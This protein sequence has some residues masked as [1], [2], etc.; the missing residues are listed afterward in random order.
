MVICNNN[1]WTSDIDEILKELPELSTL[2]GKTIMITGC[3]GLICSAVVDVLI[4]WNVTH[5]GKIQ[6][7]AAGR[8][9]KKIIER[10]APYKNER[11][12]SHV[13]YDA[14]SL[15]NNL[16]LSCDY[17]IHGASNAAP[18][19]IMR[20]PVETM[21]SNFVGVK[22]LLDYAKAIQVKRILYI[23]SSEVYGKKEVDKPSKPTEYGWIDILSSRSSYSIGKCA[24]ETLCASYYDEYG[25]DSVIVR[26]GHI[27]G[28]TALKTDSRV[29]SLWAHSVACGED[30][31]MKST[32][33]Q[34]R[35]Y[36][37][38]LDC[39]SAIIT[40]LLKG[41]SI[42]AYN[43]S[44]PDKVNIHS[45]DN[46]TTYKISA[47][48]L[49]IMETVRTL[50]KGLENETEIIAAVDQ[51]QDNV[52]KHSFAEKYNAFIQSIA[53]HMT[54]FAPFIPA[55]SALLTK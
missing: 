5:Q 37:Y 3:T 47:N 18:S 6:I 25:V 8:S 23:S 4:R 10:F 22:S 32:G 20:E 7:L 42:H 34:I 1:L 24:A 15:F 14:S 40:V 53:N 2:D 52:G 21:M 28:P 11:W 17:I 39:A 16:T 33:E 45:T 41:E 48:E 36:C 54:I 35:S 43:I 46:S 38:C 31:V 27:Y 55:L 44:N 9:S 29:S 13:P 30:I 50:A 19:D 51:M 12:F 26:P 49:S